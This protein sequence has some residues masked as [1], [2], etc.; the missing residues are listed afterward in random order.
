MSVRRQSADCVG[1]WNVPRVFTTSCV[2]QVMELMLLQRGGGP[3]PSLVVQ[4][5][6]RSVMK[7]VAAPADPV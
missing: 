5:I 2:H 1:T 6:Q 4:L 7:G 3:T